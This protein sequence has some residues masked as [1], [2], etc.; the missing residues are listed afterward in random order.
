MRHSSEKILTTFVS[1]VAGI[2]LMIAL[3]LAPVRAQS[4]VDTVPDWQKA[5]GGKLSFDVA[6]VKLADPG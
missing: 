3:N 4:A 6:S 5:A 1:G 2:A